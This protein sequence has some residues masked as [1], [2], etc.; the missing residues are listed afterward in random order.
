MHPRPAGQSAARTAEG[1]AAGIVVAAGRG[2]RL[3]GGVPKALRPLGG[4][5]LVRYAAGSLAAAGLAPIVV[6]APAEALDEM[7]AAVADVDSEVI[8]IAG[9]VTRQE[10]VA[11][12]LD[13]LPD[14]T[15][16]VLVHDAAR[17]LA[18]AELAVAVLDALRSGARAAIP[19]LPVVDTIKEVADGT[20]RGTLDRNRLVAVQ[21]PQGFDVD[22]LRAAHRAHPAPR[23]SDPAAGAP[24]DASLV[25]ALGEP[26]H[27]VPGSPDAMKITR[28]V[29]LAVAEQLLVP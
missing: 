28:P 16:W 21:T 8:V 29:D 20:V 17:A 27:V 24:D 10:S 14:G 18:P 3:G 9:G 26:V 22:L 11:A 12:A 2:H 25:E 13:R 4:R 15:R 1:R 5:P 7:R 23:G 19:G 6:T